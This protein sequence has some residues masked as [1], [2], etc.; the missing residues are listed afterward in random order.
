M[1]YKI[2]D[3][4]FCFKLKRF[5]PPNSNSI[6]L[7]SDFQEVSSPKLG[8][9]CLS[10]PCQH[11]YPTAPPR[12]RS[13]IMPSAVRIHHFRDK[14][15][16]IVISQFFYPR[17][18]KPR[19]SSACSTLTRTHTSNRDLSSNICNSRSSSYNSFHIHIQQ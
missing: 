4:N 18:Y 11:T 3:Q 2:K 14:T 19:S 15:I 13:L 17:K 7:L 12:C 16:R 6:F 5:Y 9:R 8:M 1:H 10:L